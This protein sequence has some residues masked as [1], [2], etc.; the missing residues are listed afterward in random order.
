MLLIQLTGLSG[1]GKTTIA[2]RAKNDLQ[3]MGIST[4]VVDGDEFRKHLCKGLSFSK[5]DR[6]E[7]IRR[8][9]IVGNLL[10]KNGIISIISAINPYETARN[11]LKQFG[12]HVKTVWIYCSLNKLIQRD[13][14]GLYKK[15]L[16]PDG[17]PEK[18]TNLTGIND[19]FEEP[20]QPD[21]VID[22]TKE[23][24]KES[25]ARLLEFILFYSNRNY[26]TRCG[27]R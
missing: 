20:S 21:L 1:S 6:I 17:H 14:K 19:P 5:P 11:E 26:E 10:A 3:K 24:E 23:T 9:G 15:A 16:L 2:Y 12:S 18:V 25:T 7:N 22:T 8:L 13:P 27:S 4:E